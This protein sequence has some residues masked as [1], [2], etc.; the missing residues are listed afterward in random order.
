M[1]ALD[2]KAADLLTRC[3]YQIATGKWEPE[4]KLPSV[5]QAEREWG[6]DRRTVL[7][8]YRALASRG[9]VT[10][11]D[12]SGYYVAPR[13]NLGRLA[14]HRYQ[15]EELFAGFAEA[16]GAETELSMVGVF[17]W[18]AHLAEQRAA[19]RPEVAFVEC[20]RAQAE[21][22]A[23]E[24]HRRLGL[25]CLALTL[26]ELEAGTPIP[27]HVRTLLVSGFHVPAVQD[28]VPVDLPLVSV[29]IEVAPDLMAEL[30]AGL[31]RAIVLDADET[32]ADSIRADVSELVTIPVLESSATAD[33]D[34]DL[35]RLLADGEVLALLA[36][37]L[38]GT[39]GASWRPHPAVHPI[40]FRIHG[41][42]WESIADAAGLPLGAHG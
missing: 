24:V 16:V 40:T 35:E 30:P 38:W 3:V 1:S 36:P 9:L 42:A 19:D 22:H 18:F 5:R 28:L 10:R 21:G 14:R 26:A 15:L 33:V 4:A 8:A 39:V 20:T 34:L 37:R 6:V 12:R 2:T 41:E 25:P 13:A 31:Q 29:P 11:R 32:E 17:R 27:P 7:K 23:R